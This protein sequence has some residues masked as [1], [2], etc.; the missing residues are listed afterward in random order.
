MVALDLGVLINSLRVKM[1]VFAGLGCAKTLH[2][3]I[4]SRFMTFSHCTFYWIS[5]VKS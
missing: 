4:N 1:L 2:G 3:A 5:N